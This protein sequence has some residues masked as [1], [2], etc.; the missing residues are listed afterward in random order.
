M[1]PLDGMA[2]FM[3][4]PEFDA[5]LAELGGMHEGLMRERGFESREDYMRALQ[6]GLAHTGEVLDQAGLTNDQRV[7]L[8]LVRSD[9]FTLTDNPAAGAESAREAIALN[10][11]FPGAHLLLSDAL[12]ELE[13]YAA[14][15]AAAQQALNRV[16]A[17]FDDP[18]DLQ[19]R[20]MFTLSDSMRDRPY[21]HSR[22]QWER[23]RQ[24]A[25]QQWREMIQT[26]IELTEALERAHS[27]EFNWAAATSRAVPPSTGRRL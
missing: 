14:A 16:D 19:S 12:V 6:R 23:D 25:A 22:R 1:A 26:Q 18:P 9:L 4:D 7:T 21:G 24:A 10:D 8:L 15:G 2:E 11:A 3:D 13:D 27:M 5:R 17:W 20:L